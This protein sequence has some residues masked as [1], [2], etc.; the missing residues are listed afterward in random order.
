MSTRRFKIKIDGKVFEAEVEEIDD[1]RETIKE[2]NEPVEKIS[3]PATQ[4]FSKGKDIIAPMPGKILKINVSKGM[5]VKN[6]D[7]VL[8]L[9]AMK[10]E[11]EIK[12]HVNGTVVNITVS[13]GDTVKKEQ[14]LINID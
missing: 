11:Q 4:N 6:G 13:D 8:I 1:Q 2:K 14:V 10:M 3:Q 12:S 7:V 5:K 9:E